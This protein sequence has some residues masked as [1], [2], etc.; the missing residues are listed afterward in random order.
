MAYNIL[1][2]DVEFSGVNLGN[3][4]DMINDHGNQTVGG[5]KTFTSTLTASAGLSA[6]IYYGDGS[7]LSGI[8]TSP[9]GTDR[10]IQFNTSSALS[11]NS[12]FTYDGTNVTLAGALSASFLSGS[13]ANIY[14]I[15]PANIN[16]AINAGQLNLGHGLE[17]N[18]NALRIKL[19]SDSAINRSSNGIKIQASG[20]SAVSSLGDTDL[21]V[22]D[23]SGNKKA[24]A[25]QIYNYVNGKL[26][27]PAVAGSNTQIQF[28]DSGDLGASSNLTFNSS[29]N[30]LTT[31]N[32]TAS[33]HVSASTYYGDGSNLSGISGGSSTSYNSFTANFSVS[34]SYDFIGINTSGSV[35]TGSLLAANAYSA[36]QRLVFK[37]IEG[38]GSTNNLVIEPSGSQTIDGASVAKIKVNYGSITIASDGS[39]AFYIIGNN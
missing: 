8:G 33:T 22:T 20:L 35:V 6:S 7:A 5:I 24:T 19:D 23:Q 17:D 9:G 32:I 27:I 12:G 25:L 29:T 4:E 34:A 3:I 18:S 26:T 31:T 30:T 38:S 21:F 11:G 2:D 15:T 1:K 36:G 39:G 16:G 37:D 13:G 10:S 28:N 14:N